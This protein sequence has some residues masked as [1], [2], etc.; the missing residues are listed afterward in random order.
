MRRRA[1]RVSLGTLEGQAL[2]NVLYGG[3]AFVYVNLAGAFV[4]VKPEKLTITQ[5]ALSEL[6]TENWDQTFSYGGNVG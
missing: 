2:F 3:T 1:C 5:G 4:L 6:E